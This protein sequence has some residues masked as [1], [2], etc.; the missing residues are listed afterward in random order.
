MY[1][2]PLIILKIIAETLFF[3]LVK[4]QPTDKVLLWSPYSTILSP[5]PMDQSNISFILLDPETP[6][7]TLF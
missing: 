1:V 6:T 5:Q 7:K 3:T 2:L 4:M